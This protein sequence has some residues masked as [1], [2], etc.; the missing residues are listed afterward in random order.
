VFNNVYVNS[1]QQAFELVFNKLM[2]YT[3]IKDEYKIIPVEPLGFQFSE[4]IMAANMTRDEIREKLGLEAENVTV[5]APQVQAPQTEV[6]ANLA[7]MTGRQFQQ[8]ERIKRKYEGGKLTR[9]QAS[10]MLKNSFGISDADVALF[11]DVNDTQNFKSEDEIDFEILYEFEKECENLVDFEVVKKKS[12]DKKEYF[13]D[14][15]ELTQ[16]ESDILDLI[17]KDKRITSDV[18]AKTLQ[19]DIS[20]V[21]AAFKSLF[22]KEIIKVTETKVGENKIIERERT[23]KKVDA[24]PANSKSFL[25]RYTYAWRDI[26]PFSERDTTEHP[27]RQFCVKMLDMAQ[28]KVWSRANIEAI[29]ARLGYSVWDRVGG[30]WTMP[31]GEHSVQCRH[32]WQALTVIKKN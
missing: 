7:A 15:Q 17:K 12:F 27:S 26:V 11:L 22:T 4:A 25:I 31:N 30:W 29:S 21:D 18:I 24:P 20:E 5:N 32:E 1:K 14:V 8:L 2:H 16:L 9:A 28:T 19:V 10:M 6:N 3:G 13:A 23:V